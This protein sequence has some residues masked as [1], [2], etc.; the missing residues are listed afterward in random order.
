MAGFGPSSDLGETKVLAFKLIMMQGAVLA[1][2]F[3]TMCLLLVSS[4]A[5]ECELVCHYAP[6][7]GISPPERISLNEPGETKSC[8]QH[9]ETKEGGR[10]VT[11]GYPLTHCEAKG[12]DCEFLYCDYHKAS[13]LD[14]SSPTLQPS[15]EQEGEYKTIEAKYINKCAVRHGEYNVFDGCR[16]K[17]KPPTNP[18]PVPVLADPSVEDKMRNASA[19]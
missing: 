16:L 2:A 18:T 17:A 12:A 1:E 9:K 7:P 11:S 13:N 5:T 15:D 6:S 8:S 4:S 3:L 10:I 19:H 14:L